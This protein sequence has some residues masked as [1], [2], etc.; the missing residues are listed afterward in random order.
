MSTEMGRRKICKTSV[1]E[2]LTICSNCSQPWNITGEKVSDD[3]LVRL[4]DL[5][6][7]Q[8]L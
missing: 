3:Y 5:R 6:V 1:S 2:V 7:L 8:C 4:G